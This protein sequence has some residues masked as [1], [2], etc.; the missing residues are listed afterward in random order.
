MVPRLQI[1][2][3]EAAAFS[4]R[5]R[6]EVGLLSGYCELHCT[7]YGA[8]KFS[9]KYQEPQFAVPGRVWQRPLMLCSYRRSRVEILWNYK[10]CSCRYLVRIFIS[11][12]AGKLIKC[13]LDLGPIV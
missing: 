2:A 10:R 9:K 4:T 3:C 6:T 1:T 12:G 11:I 7:E 13:S 5:Y 8:I